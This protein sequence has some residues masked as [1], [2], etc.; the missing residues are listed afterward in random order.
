[1]SPELQPFV[2]LG[3]GVA[4]SVLGFFLKKEAAK[5]ALCESKIQELAVLIATNEV[6]DVERWKVADKLLEDRRS[7][8]KNIFKK[9]SERR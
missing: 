4:L 5:S 7:D 6:R 2:F 8:I 1:M 3:V 9:L